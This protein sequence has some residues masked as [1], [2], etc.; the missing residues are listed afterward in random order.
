MPLALASSY[1]IWF[2]FDHDLAGP[3]RYFDGQNIAF[4]SS[5]A[6]SVPEPHKLNKNYTVTLHRDILGPINDKIGSAILERDSH[7]VA[8][9]S[10]VGPGTYYLTFS[11]ENDGVTLVDNEAR[12]YNY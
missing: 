3:S 12:F 4:E 5:F 1:D 2:A 9:W 10:N 8:E 6:K 7:G 11:K